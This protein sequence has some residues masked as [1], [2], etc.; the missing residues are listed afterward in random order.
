[1]KFSTQNKCRLAVDCEKFL[2][3]VN[4]QTFETK[5]TDHTNI[6]LCVGV[7]IG[8]MLSTQ[9]MLLGKQFSK[10]EPDVETSLFSFLPATT[11][12]PAQPQLTS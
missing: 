12:A 9:H 6:L 5:T 7:E 3:F 10:V 2:M 11:F 1:M 4:A 8:L